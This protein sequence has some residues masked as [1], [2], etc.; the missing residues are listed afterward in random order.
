MSERLK[1]SLVG[2]TF[3]AT[4]GGRPIPF[5]VI[6]DL[7]PAMGIC[8]CRSLDLKYTAEI[9]SDRITSLLAPARRELTRRSEMSRWIVFAWFCPECENTF[10]VSQNS[11][12]D[13]P[14]KCPFGDC[15]EEIIQKGGIT[16]EGKEVHRRGRPFGSTKKKAV[17]P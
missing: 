7:N 8:I 17:T 15:S 2:K 6:K 5:Q 3:M 1:N 9:L 4:I 12:E 14:V 13:V 10:Y 16:I 11:G